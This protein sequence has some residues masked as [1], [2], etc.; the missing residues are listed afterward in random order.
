MKLISDI[1]FITLPTFKNQFIE[2]EF[3]GNLLYEIPE[4]VLK[5]VK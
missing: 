3:R 4:I 2:I 1:K 5:N